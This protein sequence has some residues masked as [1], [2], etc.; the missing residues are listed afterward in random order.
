MDPDPKTLASA[1]ADTSDEA[2]QVLLARLK[3]ATDPDEVRRL[4]AEI[5]RLIFHKQLANA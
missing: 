5:E 3:T 2:L 1:P 4:S